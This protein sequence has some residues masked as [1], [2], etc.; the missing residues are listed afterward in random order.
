M[1]LVAGD[2][3]AVKA[4]EA[5]RR[6]EEQVLLLEQQM[7]EL[8]SKFNQPHDHANNTSAAQPASVQH[9]STIDRDDK[10]ASDRSHKTRVRKAATESL[11]LDA[12]KTL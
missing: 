2:I 9:K 10:F 4:Q 11:E 12:I 6:A 8:Q 3:D 1:E 5:Q 7:S